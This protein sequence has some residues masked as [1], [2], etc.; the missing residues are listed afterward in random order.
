MLVREGGSPLRA[1]IDPKRTVTLSTLAAAAGFAG[2]D[3][4]V[5]IQPNLGPAQRKRP[6][7]SPTGYET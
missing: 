3:H 4:T 7:N 6:T 2:L 1:A 5:D